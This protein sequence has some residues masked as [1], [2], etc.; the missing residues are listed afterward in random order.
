MLS[1]LLQRL[2]VFL[3]LRKPK[4]NYRHV[5]DGRY[6]GRPLLI[7]LENYVLATIGHLTAEKDTLNASI[8]RRIFGGGEDWRATLRIALSL[9]ASMDAELQTFWASY[10]ENARHTTS[11]AVPEAFARHVVDENFA[12]LIERISGE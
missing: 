10:Q 12:P 2:L 7:L 5:L 1:S 8:T 9:P 3:R 4:P 11:P 6:A